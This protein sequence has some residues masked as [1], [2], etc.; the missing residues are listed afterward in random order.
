VSEGHLATR[1]FSFVKE[2]AWL[3][4]TNIPLCCN[5]FSL[6][7]DRRDHTGKVRRTRWN[8]KRERVPEFLRADERN[9]KRANHFILSFLFYLP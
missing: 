6:N 1:F 9:V 7:K 4:Q 8:S 2:F 3:L 5:D